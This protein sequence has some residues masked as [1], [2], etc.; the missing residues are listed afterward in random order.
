L[1]GL[2]VPVAQLADARRAERG[3][4]VQSIFCMHDPGALAAK[5]S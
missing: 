3:Y 4:F 5:L 2:H 1:P